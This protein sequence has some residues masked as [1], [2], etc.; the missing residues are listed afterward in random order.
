MDAEKAVDKI[1]HHF[2]IKTLKKLGLEEMYHNAIKVIQDKFTAN[3]ML[4]G[5]Q[6][7]SFSVKSRTRQ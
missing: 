5:E 2:I 3:I 1:Q 6:L 7:K 4:N